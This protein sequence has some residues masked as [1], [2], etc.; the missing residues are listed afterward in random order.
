[1][2]VQV[3]VVLSTE[4]RPLDAVIELW[5]V[6][7]RLRLRLRPPPHSHPDPHPDSNPDPGSNPDSDPDRDPDPDSDPDPDLDLDS[8]PNPELWQGPDNTPCS[9]RVYVENGQLR[10]FTAVIETPH[11]SGVTPPVPNPPTPHPGGAR[12]WPLRLL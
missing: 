8:N 10:P 5:Q 6:R 12:A 1:M 2:P 7:L 3:Q 11:R 9:M 4:G